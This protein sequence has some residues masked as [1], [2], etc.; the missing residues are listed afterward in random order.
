MNT[1]H[2]Q[3]EWEVAERFNIIA[4]GEYVGDTYQ[5]Y[6]T[7]EKCEAN[8]KAIVTAVNNTYGKGINP[9]AVPDLLGA[10][11]TLLQVNHH[12]QEAL[13]NAQEISVLAIKKAIVI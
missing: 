5:P 8:A 9:E 2:T 12:D 7:D 10:L 13:L 1:K 11:R 3:G 4:D 6:I